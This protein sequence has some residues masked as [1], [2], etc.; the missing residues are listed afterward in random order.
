MELD[1]TWH[2]GNAGIVHR[3]IEFIEG[4]GSF[5]LFYYFYVCLLQKLVWNNLMDGENVHLSPVRS[6]SL[7]FWI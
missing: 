1:E 2:K 5:E 4:V 7:F 6:L 3:M